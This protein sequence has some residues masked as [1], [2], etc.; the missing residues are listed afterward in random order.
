MKSCDKSSSQ[1]DGSDVERCVD[2]INTNLHKFTAS[3]T[4]PVQPEA[5]FMVKH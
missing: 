2:A 1:I 4:H 5:N 3:K